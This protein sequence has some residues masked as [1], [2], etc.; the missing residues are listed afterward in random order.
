KQE[1]LGWALTPC[2]KGIT[3]HLVMVPKGGLCHFRFSVAGA[4]MRDHAAAPL[5]RSP[6]HAQRSIRAKRAAS[7]GNSCLIKDTFY[8][9][10]PLASAYALTVPLD[11]VAELLRILK[12][13]ATTAPSNPAST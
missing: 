13:N 1:Y 4:C 10:S 9:Q 11:F 12:E 8:P 5:S 7:S 6:G 3:H 2:Q